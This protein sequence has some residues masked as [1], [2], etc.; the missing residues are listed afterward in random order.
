VIVAGLS[1]I[2]AFFPLLPGV[3]H[4]VPQNP[5]PKETLD[6]LI[7]FLGVF[8]TLTTVVFGAGITMS[9]GKSEA[10]DARIDAFLGE[11][12]E[13]LGLTSVKLL[14]DYEFYPHFRYHSEAAK[15][16]VY[17]SYFELTPPGEPGREMKQEYYRNH[18]ELVRQNERVAFRRIIR[19]SEPNKTWVRQIIEKELHDVGNAELAIYKESKSQEMPLALSVQ[20]VDAV[21]VWFVA[22][23]THGREREPRD[24]F[25]ENCELGQMMEKYYNRLWERS[26]VVF[27]NGQL[28]AEGRAYMQ[29]NARRKDSQLNSGKQDAQQPNPGGQDVQEG[30]AGRQNGQ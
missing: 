6:T 11:I 14:Q 15:R 3:K 29:G 16:S 22:V 23:A 17:I 13:K 8:I 7:T 27:R 21:K 18:F 20:I 10:N 26:E 19:D 5:T 30:D 24:I 25:I 9:L 12:R 28:T 4:F 1:A 2:A